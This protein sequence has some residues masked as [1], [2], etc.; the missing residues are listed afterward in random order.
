MTFKT[1]LCT[2]AL[3]LCSA[4]SS[5]SFADECPVK[6]TMDGEKIISTIAAAKSCYE[7]S[8]VAESCAW[9]SSMDV[10]FV[11]A[12]LKTCEKDF[13]KISKSNRAMYNALV[14]DCGKKYAKQ[15]GTMYVSM[16]AF[17]SLSV[18]KTFSGIFSPIEE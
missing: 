5:V 14:S 1:L 3:I 13:T 18:A 12:A 16:T 17:C 7:A 9:G 2:S 10:Q 6:D 8:T 15:Q 4:L 11:G